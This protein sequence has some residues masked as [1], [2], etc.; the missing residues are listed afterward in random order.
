MKLKKVDSILLFK[1]VFQKLVVVSAIAGTDVVGSSL[2]MAVRFHKTAH[3]L[4]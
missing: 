2:P 1:S 4:N 3:P